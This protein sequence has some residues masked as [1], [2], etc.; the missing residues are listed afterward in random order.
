MLFPLKGMR[1]TR[2]QKLTCLQ[3]KKPAYLFMITHTQLLVTCAV[4][5]DHNGHGWIS[6]SSSSLGTYLLLLC[7]VAS[8]ESYWTE[9]KMNYPWDS[10]C[11]KH[12][13]KSM[14]LAWCWEIP[15]RQ[16]TQKTEECLFTCRTVQVLA[17]T[18]AEQKATCCAVATTLCF[19]RTFT[20]P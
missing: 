5:A 18:T 12:G 20:E 14:I 6:S 2:N 9:W 15:R 3:S 1:S 17:I 10:H 19:A 8:G 16:N 4:A 11:S 13:A 7:L